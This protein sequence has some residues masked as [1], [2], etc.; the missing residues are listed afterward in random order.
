MSTR[1]RQTLTAAAFALGASM[2]PASAASSTADNQKAENNFM[3]INANITLRRLVVHNPKPKPVV[4]FLH[5]FPETLY[6]WQDVSLM[7][8]DDY[9]IHA[10]DWPGYGLSSRPA[11]DKFSYA[12]RDYADVLREYIRAA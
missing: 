11:A 4:L 8:A 6:V 3:A 7:L 12:P 10:F 2:S 9:E 1:A 5:G